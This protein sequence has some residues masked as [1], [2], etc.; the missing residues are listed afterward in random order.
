MSLSTSNIPALTNLILIDLADTQEG[1]SNGF[2]F[3]S[4]Y[5]LVLV[6]TGGRDVDTSPR[7]LHNLLDH[8][9]EGPSNEWVEGLLQTQTLHSPLILEKSSVGLTG[10]ET[11]STGWQVTCP[12]PAS[13]PAL[14]I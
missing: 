14:G 13:S 7:F 3:T 2:L 9:V 10:M 5:D 1:L 11:T 4:D 6:D 8:F 12:F